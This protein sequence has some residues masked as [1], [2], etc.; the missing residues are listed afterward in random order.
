MGKKCAVS[1]ENLQKNISTMKK[2]NSNYS[3]D[4]CVGDTTP[5]CKLSPDEIKKRLHELGYQMD[6]NEMMYNGMTGEPME[7]MIFIGPTYY[8]RLKH[9]VDD[10]IHSRAQGPNQALTRQPLEGRAQDGGLRVGKRYILPQSRGS[11]LC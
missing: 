2:N 3:K 6:G 7:A 9:M 11:N 5:F 4:H 1:N 8:Q 10:K